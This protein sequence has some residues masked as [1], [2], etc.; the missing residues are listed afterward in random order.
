MAGKIRINYDDLEDPKVD[1]TLARL[2]EESSFRKGIGTKTGPL[3][4]GQVSL[5]HKSWFHLMIAGLIGALIAWALIEPYLEDVKIAQGESTVFA[6]LMYLSVGG[7]V[8]LMVGCMEGILARN[9]LRALK[10]G[11]V[12]LVIG[13]GGGFVAVFVAGILIQ[14]IVPIGVSIIG[15]EAARDPMHNFSG[16]M[17]NVIIRSLIWA[18]LGMTVGLGPGIGLKSK[19]LALNGF[20]GGM[21]GGAI[22]G[23]LFDP[24]YYVV[25]SGGTLEK[26]AA[27]SR[28]IGF[29]VVG[30]TAG[31]MIGLVEM[32]TKDA[33]L[34]MTAGLLKG[35][36]FIVYKNPTIIG[37]SPKCEIYLF[38][39]PS[40]EPTHA[41]IHII[42]DGYEIEDMNT[43]SGTL[44]NRRKVRRQKLA[45]GDEIQIGET[46]FIYSEKEKK[47]LSIQT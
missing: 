9:F 5:I 12:G 37:S 28:A 21:I 47:S 38:K 27:L 40:I 45:N 14:I 20:L 3:E 2:D 15:E 16:F 7:L 13:F 36:Q 18:E 41:A 19:K 8:G 23:L 43:S 32:L 22:G 24:V 10:A 6:L 26:E 31:L 42:R 46:K 35:K 39:D 34:L 11:V 44:V 29:G 33:W 30:A 25:S 4:K 17:L 1:E